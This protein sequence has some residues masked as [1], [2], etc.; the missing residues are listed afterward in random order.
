MFENAV[1]MSV[2]GWRKRNFSRTWTSQ[3]PAKMPSKLMVLL[4]SWLS[5]LLAD[6]NF[7]LS[8]RNIK[9]F[10]RE[11]YNSKR[12][13]VIAQPRRLSKQTTVLK[14]LSLLTSNSISRSN[15]I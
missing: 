11:L 3:F 4:V 5:S 13:S 7:F 10:H 2:C 15:M 1:F 6:K 9:S 14:H 8:L 12:L